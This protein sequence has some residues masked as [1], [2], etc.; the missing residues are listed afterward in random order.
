MN[1]P[2]PADIYECD[3]LLTKAVE[4]RDRHGHDPYIR[5]AVPLIID[6]LLDHRL[7]LG[8]RRAR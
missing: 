5:A 3:L 2:A 7:K 1:I 6:G 4:H 8:N